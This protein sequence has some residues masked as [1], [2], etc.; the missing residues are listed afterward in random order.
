MAENL[1]TCRYFS[2]ICYTCEKCLYCFKSLQKHPCKCKKDKK[3]Q[4]TSNPKPGQ[5]IYYHV[6]T[7]NQVLLSADLFLLAVNNKFDYNNNFEESFTYIFCNAYN[8]KFQWLRSKDKITNNK[9][10]VLN[11]SS[12]ESEKNLSSKRVLLKK[13]ILIK[14]KIALK[15]IVLRRIAKK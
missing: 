12:K 9:L 1:I 5:Q 11:T 8:N 6:F 4:R 2:D 15:K 13:I 3:S 7:P 14:K 10:D